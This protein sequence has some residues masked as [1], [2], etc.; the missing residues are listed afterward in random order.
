MILILAALIGAT[1]AAPVSDDRPRDTHHKRWA[2]AG[3]T[4][5]VTHHLIKKQRCNRHAPL[6][7]A[8]KTHL[9]ANHGCKKR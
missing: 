6:H 7:L 1:A 8:G 9:P 4:P 3:K 2:P 5:A